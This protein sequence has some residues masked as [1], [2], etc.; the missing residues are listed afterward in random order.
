MTILVDT[1]ILLRAADSTHTLHSRAVDA[2]ASAAN[3]GDTLCVAPQNLYEFWVV[4]TRPVSENGLGFN[5]ADADV[6]LNDLAHSFQVLV[7]TADVLPTWR[8]LVRD[9]SVSGKSAHDARLAAIM[10]VHQISTI[11]TFNPAHFN[12]YPQVTV[13]SPEDSQTRA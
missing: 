5:C 7:E 12:R 6:L 9:F 11:L 4:A 1:N 3:R 10:L 2:I 13:S 8:A